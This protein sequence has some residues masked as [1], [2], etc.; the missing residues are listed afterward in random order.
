M[1][2]S[3]TVCH[4]S[5]TQGDM[6]T[7]VL[8]MPKERICSACHVETEELKRHRQQATAG[9]CVSCHDAHSSNQRMLLRI[10]EV[11]PPRM[12]KR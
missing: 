10:A 4:V 1:E 7:I 9:T 6:T 11:V 3:C 12:K 8:A 2:T 5:R